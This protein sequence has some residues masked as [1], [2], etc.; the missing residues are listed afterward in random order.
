LEPLSDGIRVLLWQ[1]AAGVLA[2][3]W[4]ASRQW[5]GDSLAGP[6]D[7]GPAVLQGRG[8]IRKYF[9][10]TPPFL[11]CVVIHFTFAHAVNTTII[12]LNEIIL[13]QARI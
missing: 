8:L 10:L 13:C 6:Q 4:Q 7:G 9:Q 3:A 11:T 12:A 1:A 2:V 5:A